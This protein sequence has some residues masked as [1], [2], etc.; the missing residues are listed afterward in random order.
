MHMGRSPASPYPDMYGSQ[1]CER[2]LQDPSFTTLFDGV[3]M[4]VP[5]ADTQHWHRDSGLH[6]ECLSHVSVHVSTS[7][8]TEAMGPTQFLPGT[9]M[10]FGFQFS[11]WTGFFNHCPNLTAPLLPAG[12]LLIWEYRTLHRG[13]RNTEAQRPMLY[14]I[15]RLRDT[16]KDINMGRRSFYSTVLEAE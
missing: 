6:T 10:D 13:T 14:K 4:S 5:G 3:L 2:F 9:N 16:W 7:D 15:F 8:V 12:G 11:E 1:G